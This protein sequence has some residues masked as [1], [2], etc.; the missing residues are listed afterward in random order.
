MHSYNRQIISDD[1]GCYFVVS[2]YLLPPSIRSEVQVKVALVLVATI[3][4]RSVDSFQSPNLPNQGF[5]S[6]VLYILVFF[7][8]ACGDSFWSEEM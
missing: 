2:L 1:D 4:H 6:S 8:C 5:I 7:W 3:P